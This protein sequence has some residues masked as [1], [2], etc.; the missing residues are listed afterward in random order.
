MSD[1]TETEYSRTV[2]PRDSA[3]TIVQFRVPRVDLGGA[4]VVHVF[5]AAARR[6]IVT[7]SFLMVA[8]VLR[9]VGHHRL[10]DTIA[11][12]GTTVASDSTPTRH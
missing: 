9:S 1:D 8:S 6:K 12:I 11:R 3:Y 5:G 7:A 10:G 4:A 2:C